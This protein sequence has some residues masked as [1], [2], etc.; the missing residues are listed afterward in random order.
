MTRH[1]DPLDGGWWSRRGSLALCLVLLAVPAVG[2]LRSSA[3][4]G[5]YD[6]YFFLLY[7]TDLAQSAHE[8]SFAR[9]S[10]FPG[11]YAFWEAVARAAGRNF[12]AYQRAFAGVGLANAALTGLVVRAAGGGA[13]LA[14]SSVCGY[15]VFGERLELGLMTTE[16]LATLAP[17][18]SVLIL[19]TLRRRGRERMGLAALGAG[20]GIAVFTKQQGAFV[21]LGAVGLAPFLWGRP[22]SWRSGCV[23]AATVVATALAVFALAMTVDGGGIEAVKLGVATAVDYQSRGA[24]GVHLVELAL[25]TPLLFAA[26][27][28]AACA[29]PLAVASSRH[30]P[31]RDCDELL[32][33]WGLGATTALATL[34]Q[35]SK[36][37][38]AHY[39]LLTLPYALMAIALAASWTLER[40]RAF[41][42]HAGV[43]TV[44][45][46]ASLLGVEA[47]AL[48]RPQEPASAP[49]HEGYLPECDGIRQGER[50]LLLPSRQNALHW[51]C[52]TNA[53]GTRWGYTFN[54]QER[55]DEYIAELAKPELTQVFVFKADAAHPYEQE[56]AGRHD[57][58]VFFDALSRSG[59]RAVATR[60]AGTLYQ[61]PAHDRA[62]EVQGDV[63]E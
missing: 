27:V 37:G 3:R 10:Y 47:W 52:G 2:F 36:R 45:S 25:K 23:D 62:H 15:L 39:A 63:H 18:L 4:F 30:R 16:A 22:R 17:L 33:V 9:Y 54:F 41:S 24:L 56:I 46:A 53:R 57:W 32:L 60:P 29:W 43:A 13:L 42:A 59:F 44:V 31:D 55:P 51:A 49:L 28:G 12:A 8:T 61:R 58:S 11:S 7:A 40:L 1:A 48:H 6:C 35:F 21:A 50:L 34:F 20:Y 5:G 26:L 38:Y 14:A 19:V